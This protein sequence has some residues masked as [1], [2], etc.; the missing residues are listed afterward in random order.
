MYATAIP[1]SYSANQPRYPTAG[2][3]Y[4][5]TA[6]LAPERIKNA[7]S[8]SIGWIG[9]WRLPGLG[10][11]NLTRLFRYVRMDSLRSQR[12]LPIGDNDPGRRRS[13]S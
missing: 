1:E 3:Q 12:P 13:A 5:F 6:K 11:E 8:W 9:V 4:H 10:F 7:L 2:G